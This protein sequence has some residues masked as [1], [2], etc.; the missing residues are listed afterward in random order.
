MA[1]TVAGWVWIDGLTAA[2]RSNLRST[3]TVRPRKTTDIATVKTPDPIELFREDGDRFAVPRGYW[4]MNRSG[5]HEEK[6]AVSYGQPMRPLTSTWRAEGPFAEQAEIVPT[7]Q[8]AIMGGAWGGGILN[9][10]CRTGKT[11]CTTELAHRVGRTTMILVHKGFLLK[12][13]KEDIETVLPGARVGIVQQDQEE[14]EDVDFCIG[15]LQSLALDDGNRYDQRMYS[16][17]G[18]LVSDEVHRIAANTWN[19]VVPRFDAAYRLG[20]SATLDRADRAENVFYYQ[21]GLVVYKAEA[22]AMTP[23]VRVLKT[24]SHVHAISRGRYQVKI[25]KL[26]SAQIITQLSNDVERQRQIVDQILRAI[27]VGRKILVMSERLEHLRDMWIMTRNAV[28]VLSLPWEVT[29][30]FCTGKWFVSER[31]KKQRLVNDDEFKLANRAQ[32]IWASKQLVEEGYTNPALDVFVLATP[33]AN[34]EQASSRVRGWCTPDP[35][36]CEWLC[37]WRVGSCQGKADP[38]FI[39]VFDA[40]IPKVLGKWRRRQRLY[41]EMGAR[42]EV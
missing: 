11:F 30:G 9:A 38:V 20:L 34:V 2:Q 5:R 29:H 40:N 37:P 10:G 7:L 1:A 32:V 22:K 8:H 41:R 17:F 6:V 25:E 36:K 26:N 31:G 28:P 27:R 24:Q 18:L 33:M 4:A 3:L 21:I 16:R 13:W 19:V 23:K 15:L 12:Q 14:W 42:V 39:D 35:G